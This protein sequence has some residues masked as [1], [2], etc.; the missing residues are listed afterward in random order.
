[1]T[2][3]LVSEIR[4]LIKKSGVG[5]VVNS[6]GSLFTIF[7]SEGEVVDYESASRSDRK[8]YAN[9]FHHLLERGVYFAPSPLEANFLSASHNG[10]DLKKTL[11]AIAKSLN[12]RNK[13]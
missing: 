4:K 11:G 6:V 5:A 10:H 1:M 8:V 7:F 13:K 9:F 3:G 2:T 12:R